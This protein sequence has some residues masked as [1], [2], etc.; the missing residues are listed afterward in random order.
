MKKFKQS[1]VTACLFIGVS[2][3]A[4]ATCLPEKIYMTRHAEKL[5]EEGNRDPG[6]SAAGKAR[7]ERLA[8]MFTDIKVDHLLST[9]YKRTQQTL[10]PLSKAKNLEV[11]LYDPRKGKEFIKQLKND[12]C[13]QTLVVSGHS[14]TV[15]NMLQ[16]LGV[17]FEVKVGG[18]TFKHQPSIILSEAEFGQLFAISFNRDKPVLEVLS[19]NG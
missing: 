13:K 16:A 17:K 1:L 11:T 10:M 3:T 12:Y 4:M 6:L 2:Q 18:Y 8:R 9:P 19:S 14:N 15:P 7:A 5:I